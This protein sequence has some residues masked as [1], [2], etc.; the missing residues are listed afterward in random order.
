MNYASLCT[1]TFHLNKILQNFCLKYFIGFSLFT[2]CTGVVSQYTCVVL[3]YTG[4]VLQY[5]GVV[6]QHTSVVLKYR[7]VVL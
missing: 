5:T 1:K 4:V 6:L 3:Q 7:C 2:E